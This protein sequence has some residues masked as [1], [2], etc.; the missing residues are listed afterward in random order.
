MNMNS[1]YKKKKKKEN[2]VVKTKQ[3]INVQ[4]MNNFHSINSSLSTLTIEQ[5]RSNSNVKT[6][7]A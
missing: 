5:R 4:S 2:E 3:F 7:I 6:L 1:T